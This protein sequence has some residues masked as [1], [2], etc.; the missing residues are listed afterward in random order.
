LD[1]GLIGNEIKN[2]SAISALRKKVSAT[3]PAD[4]F[5]G[6]YK[7]YDAV[8]LCHDQGLVP[9]KRFLDG[10]V[11]YRRLLLSGHLTHGPAYDITGKTGFSDH[12]ETLLSCDIFRNRLQYEISQLLNPVDI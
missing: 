4:T 10:G 6:T 1:N 2:H 9:L 12:S 11:I 7:K 3:I 5:A 8:C